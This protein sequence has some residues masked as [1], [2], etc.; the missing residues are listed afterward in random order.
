MCAKTI[1]ANTLRLSK[2]TK[3]TKLKRH[4]AKFSQ[5]NTVF[6]IFLI[7][8]FHSHGS[9]HI[10]KMWPSTFC[11]HL[12]KTIYLGLVADISEQYVGRTV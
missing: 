4:K 2:N 6:D 12:Q 9:I 8:F 1:A 7:Y 10:D 11:M 3:N 5:L